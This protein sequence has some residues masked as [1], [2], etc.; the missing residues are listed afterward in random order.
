MK[1]KNYLKYVFVVKP[2]LLWFYYTYLVHSFQPFY[3]HGPTQQIG[4]S[5]PD[6]G[7]LDHCNLWN[8]KFLGFVL[9]PNLSPQRLFKFYRRNKIIE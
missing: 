9:K 7:P 5:G 4:P 3:P 2:Q 1:I 6:Q 8:N